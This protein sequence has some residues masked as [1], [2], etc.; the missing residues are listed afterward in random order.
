MLR[1]VD[2]ASAVP[3]PAKPARHNVRRVRFAAAVAH[4]AFPR[5]GRAVA[6]SAQLCRAG[7]AGR[8]T[9]FALCDGG[10]SCSPANPRRSLGLGRLP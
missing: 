8:G 10:D 7:F 6:G 9:A 3:R 5:D 4:F 1:L 2:L